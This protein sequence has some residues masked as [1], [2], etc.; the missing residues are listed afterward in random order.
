[1]N[2]DIQRRCQPQPCS[3]HTCQSS[4]GREAR[5][6]SQGRE[7]PQGCSSARTGAHRA[8]RG[9]PH[10]ATRRG[11]GAGGDQYGATNAAAGG[12]GEATGALLRITNGK[13]RN[14]AERREQRS[15]RGLRGA[16]RGCG[17]AGSEPRREERRRGPGCAAPHG[18]APRAGG[19]AGQALV[20]RAPIDPRAPGL[21]QT[22]N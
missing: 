1:M 12:A 19:G 3:M 8:H 15:A 18:S 5:H 2:C 4:R 17:A 10:A 7:P 16:Q 9:S 20:P 21:R 13:L 6:H 11:D 22:V 14:P